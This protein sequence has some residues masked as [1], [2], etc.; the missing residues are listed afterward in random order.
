[1][2]ATS[3]RPR[4]VLFDFFGTLTRAVQRGPFHSRI[5]H[6]LG[7]DPDRFASVLNRTFYARACGGYGSPRDGLRRLLAPLGVYPGEELLAETVVARVAA[8][9]DDTVLRPEAVPVLMQLRQQ[10]ILTAVVSDCWFELPAFLPDLP[11]APLLNTCVYSVDVG[12][13]KPHPAMYLEACARLRI[14]PD[15]CLYVGDGGS[16]ELSGAQNVGIRAV[17]LDAADLADHLVFHADESWIGPS[18]ETLTDVL[19]Q[20]DRAPVP[21]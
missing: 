10:G 16:A 15:E 2:Y 12:H 7:V 19:G 6:R 5:A 8:V 17:R 9:R 18:V 20:L 13:C 4:A 14:E 1:M 21:A 11:V 3:P